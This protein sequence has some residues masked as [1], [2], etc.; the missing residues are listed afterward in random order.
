MSRKALPWTVPLTLIC[1]AILTLP[2]SAQHFQQVKGTLTQIAAGRNEVFGVDA[3]SNIWRYNS[4]QKGFVSIQGLLVQVAVGGGT[5]SQTDDV[6][7]V[8]G[9]GRVFRFNYNTKLFVSTGKTT[10]TSITVGV[11]TQDKCHPY[12]VWGIYAPSQFAYR[13]DYCLKG[14][15]LVPSGLTE[16]ATGGGDVWGVN[17]ASEI[18]HYDFATEEFV[19][20]PGVLSQISVGI[21]DVWGVNGSAQI[22]RYDASTGSFPQVNGVALQI[23]AG[24]DGVWALNGSDQIFRFD[25]SSASLIQVS[26]FLTNIAAGSGAGVWGINSAQQVFTFVRP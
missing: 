20:V 11:G 6:W 17:G 22:Y 24:G 7:G 13:Y 26:G 12:E 9:T 5:V 8:N 3:A 15:S 10:L 1:C 25:P 21:N 4:T 23:S 18:F 19:Q 2:A 16:V 14:F